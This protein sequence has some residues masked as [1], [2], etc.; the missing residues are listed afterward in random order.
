MTLDK[1]GSHILSKY[2]KEP[3]KNN[4]DSLNL[5]NIANVK[6]FY[7]VVLPFVGKHHPGEKNF[8][9]AGDINRTSYRFPFES[10]NILGGEYPKKEITLL[11]N[12]KSGK[13]EGRELKKADLIAFRR[14]ASSKLTEFYGELLIKCPVIIE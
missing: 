2:G 6:L 4:V 8:L 3:S 10:G 13:L 12:G 11:V 5:V 9:L 7:T 14:D 1:F